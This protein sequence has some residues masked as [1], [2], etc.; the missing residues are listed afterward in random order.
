MVRWWR[1]YRMMV[2]MVV[3]EVRRRWVV[4]RARVVAVVVR[5]RVVQEVRWRWPFEQFRRVRSAVGPRLA[6]L[7][8]RV[9]GA[10]PIAVL[11]RSRTRVFTICRQIIQTARLLTCTNNIP[12][13]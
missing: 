11:A 5:R 10:R 4:W 6:P 9:I 3:T 2:V 13:I 7:A 8:A 12:I 1:G